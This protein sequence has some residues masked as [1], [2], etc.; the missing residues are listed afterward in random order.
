MGITVWG[1]AT[2]RTMRAH[3]AVHELGLDYQPKLIGSRS[4]ATQSEEFRALNTKE[5]IPVLVDDDLVLTESAAIVTY[6]GDKYGALTPPVGSILRARYDEWMSFIQMELDAHTLYII[7]RHVGLAELYGEA[8]NAIAAAK[9]GFNKQVKWAIPRLSAGNYA[10]GDEFSGVDI[11]LTTTLDMAVVFGF[12]LERELEV[13]RLQ[14]AER[15][16]YKTAIELNYS[17]SPSSI[18]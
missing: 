18:G 9:D 3:W 17:I 1:G 14:Q 4:G 6:L 15:P 10:L 16:A 2:P 8:P 11:M 13:Y 12:E 7:R 5:K